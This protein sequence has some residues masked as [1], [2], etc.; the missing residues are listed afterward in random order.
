MKGLEQLSHAEHMTEDE[1]GLH[2]EQFHQDLSLLQF[3]QAHAV[4][5]NAVSAEWCE[6]CGNE[7]PEARRQAVP[8]VEL[9]ID[10][11]RAA[12]KMERMQR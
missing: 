5:P 1:L 8:G 4:P 10:C 11:A 6:D 7:I 12:E 2:N 9:C 3:K